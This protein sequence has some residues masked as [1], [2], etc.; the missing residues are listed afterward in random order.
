MPAAQSASPQRPRPPSSDSPNARQ[1]RERA[2]QA[3]GS[4]DHSREVVEAASRAERRHIATL[5][6]SAYRGEHDFFAAP[7]EEEA[8]PDAEA[9]QSSLHPATPTAEER[10]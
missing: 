9:V 6:E 4:P 8:E 5:L 1:A 2:R 10:V 7:D 3:T